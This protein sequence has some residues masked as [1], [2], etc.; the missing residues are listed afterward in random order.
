M[1]E[2][3][4]VSIIELQNMSLPFTP[5]FPSD[6][7]VGELTYRSEGERWSSLRYLCIFKGAELRVKVFFMDWFFTGFPKCLMKNFRE[8]YSYTDILESKNGILFSGK[9]YR[10]RDSATFYSKGST[11][12]IEA[13]NPFSM[14]DFSDFVNNL[15]TIVT[16]KPTPGDLSFF[17]RSFSCRGKQTG[18]FEEERVRRLTWKVESKK[19]SF[20]KMRF[21]NTGTGFLPSDPDEHWI[22]VFEDPERDHAV[23]IEYLRNGSKLKYG[24]YSLD[25]RSNFF[26]TMPEREKN[27]ITLNAGNYGPLV[28]QTQLEHGTLT[29][30]FSPGI[31]HDFFPEF[32]RSTIFGLLNLKT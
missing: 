15:T 20:D 24:K 5:F 25:G 17:Q 31:C 22:S 30:A 11:V 23:W 16:T 1:Q 32:M 29:V 26:A 4:S 14:S 13:F 10:G 21:S 7:E 19:F 6:I 2:M 28:S 27:I 9:N 8:T 3:R 18:W 12:E